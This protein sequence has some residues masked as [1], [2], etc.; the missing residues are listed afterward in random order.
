MCPTQQALWGICAS[1][2]RSNHTLS[3]AVASPSS[4]IAIFGPHNLS[5]TLLDSFSYPMC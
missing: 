1:K 5:V 2:G 3:R 4:Q